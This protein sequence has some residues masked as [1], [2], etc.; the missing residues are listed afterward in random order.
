METQLSH[1]TWHALGGVV[2][3]AAARYRG[4]SPGIG[5]GVGYVVG[6]VYAWV[7]FLIDGIFEAREMTRCPLCREWVPSHATV[8]RYCA[9]TVAPLPPFAP[10]SPRLVF[11][12]RL[13]G[14]RAVDRSGA[15]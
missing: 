12:R 15:V 2:G 3:Y 7:L 9:H 13:A 1:L 6:P 8:C 4:F 5:P 14:E 10:G 11:S